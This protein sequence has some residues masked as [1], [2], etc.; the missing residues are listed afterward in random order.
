MKKKRLTVTIGT[1]AFNEENNIKI[2]LESVVGQKEKNIIIKEIIVLS[3]G[4]TD[5][6][7]EIAESFKDKRIRVVD[8]RKRLG[9]PSRIAQLLKMFKS[10]ALV[11]ID[12]DMILSDE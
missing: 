2:M 12:S 11:L 6:T 5:R 8:S 7:V 3:D 9:Q 10:D 1:A 4:S